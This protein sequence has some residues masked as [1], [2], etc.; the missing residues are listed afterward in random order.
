VLQ[1]CKLEYEE[2]KIQFISNI[3]AMAPFISEFSS[4]EVFYRLKLAEKLTF[5]QLILLAIIKNCNR[6]LK[7]DNY[8]KGEKGNSLRALLLE[9]YDLYNLDL[10]ENYNYDDKRAYSLSGILSIEPFNLKLT[11]NGERQYEFID[12]SSINSD[13]INNVASMLM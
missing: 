11:K 7:K 12:L 3:F 5:R 8:I 4:E 13:Y 6:S 2:L 1:K 9:I 10:V